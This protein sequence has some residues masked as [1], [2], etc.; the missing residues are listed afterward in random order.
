MDISKVFLN[1]FLNPISSINRKSQK[2]SRSIYPW[3]FWIS[4]LC[5]SRSLNDLLSE[6]LFVSLKTSRNH[7]SK[8][9]NGTTRY[10]E[11]SWVS[12]LLLQT[13]EIENESQKIVMVI[14]TTLREIRTLT[15]NF[16]I[17]KRW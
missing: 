11:V 1:P 4:I 16:Q 2:Q 14:S 8:F 5:Q 12:Y 17:R 6:F 3:Y 15:G 10:L 7:S 9:Q 13:G